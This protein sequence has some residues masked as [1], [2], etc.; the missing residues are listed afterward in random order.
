MEVEFGSG[1]VDG[2]FS[3]DDVRFGPL[4]IKNQEFG[5]IIK[6]EGE[7]FKKIKFEGTFSLTIGILGL[8]FPSLSNLNHKPIFDNIISQNLLSKNYFSFYLA[9][10]NEESQS[11]IIF[12]E[13][14]HKFYKGSITWHKVSEESYWQV[15]MKDIRIND[16]NLN[17]CP[18]DGCKLVIDTGTSIITGPEEDLSV[19]LDKIELNSCQD[20]SN[21]PNVAFK[22]DDVYYELN[23][24]EYLIFA[25]VGDRTL[26]KKAF[27][28]L[29][30]PEPRGPLWVLGDI[31]LRKY[32][33]VFDRDNKR[34]GI[35][36][37]NKNFQE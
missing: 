17:L 25:K 7:I 22:I 21:L 16:Q 9:D 24:K 15:Q 18:L 27:M 12:G 34:I 31:F 37:R 1:K 33:V 23:P 19:V 29:N 13:P 30:I 2:V 5:E 10:Q 11:Q 36:L 8:S 20:L 26:C 32:F 28:P 35:A 3:R 4:F 14:S 6:E